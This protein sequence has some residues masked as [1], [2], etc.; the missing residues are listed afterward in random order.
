MPVIEV[1]LP[2]GYGRD[3]IAIDT[4]VVE[5]HQMVE[6]A[7]VIEEDEGQKGIVIGLGD[8]TRLMFDGEGKYNP[9]AS[10]YETALVQA[11]MK[12]EE[13]VGEVEPDPS[14]RSIYY[15]YLS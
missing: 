15:Y 5:A 14:L 3:A 12:G 10:A 9:R 11:T 6:F 2:E 4:S 1:K 13:V 8:G 7:R